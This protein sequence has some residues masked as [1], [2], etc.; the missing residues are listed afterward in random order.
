MDAAPSVH[1]RNGHS[2]KYARAARLSGSSSASRSSASFSA[3]FWRSGAFDQHAASLHPSNLSSFVLMVS[4]FT[5]SHPA[6]ARHADAHEQFEPRT[7]AWVLRRRD[8]VGI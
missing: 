5:G 3:S 7:A 6:A 1:F 4:L 8:P 2:A